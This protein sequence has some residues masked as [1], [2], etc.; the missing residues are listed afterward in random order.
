MR[1]RTFTLAKLYFQFLMPKRIPIE[2][3]PFLV[4]KLYEAG[5][6]E[7]FAPSEPL[8]AER[9]TENDKLTSRNHRDELF[10]IVESLKGAQ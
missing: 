3:L 6:I 9:Y 1:Q 8:G 7:V 5:F 4:S 10:K 2:Q